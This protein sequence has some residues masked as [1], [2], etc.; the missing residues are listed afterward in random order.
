[1]VVF[2]AASEA[3]SQRNIN[4]AS[5]KA[6][7]ASAP[8][9]AMAREAGLKVRAAVSCALGCPYQGEVSADEVEHVVKLM[10]AIGVDHCGIADT[11]GT[12]TP[13]PRAGGDGAGAE[14]LPA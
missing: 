14:A 3:F 9:V 5:P 1:V 11:I 4:C 8:V 2:G 12:G 7:S 10:K 13:K 6:S